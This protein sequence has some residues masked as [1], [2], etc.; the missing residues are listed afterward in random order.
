MPMSKLQ[1]VMPEFIDKFCLLQKGY[2]IKYLSKVYNSNCVIIC[3]SRWLSQK[4]ELA[5]Q[6]THWTENLPE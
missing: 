4:T 6:G 1:L 3:K 2:F 5:S